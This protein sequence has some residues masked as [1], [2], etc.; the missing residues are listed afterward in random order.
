[1][2]S[3]TAARKTAL[4]VLKAVRVVL[5]ASLCVVVKLVT[6]LWTS[7]GLMAPKARFSHVG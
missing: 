4:T 2:R 3:R 5:A 6:Q 1:M 7:P